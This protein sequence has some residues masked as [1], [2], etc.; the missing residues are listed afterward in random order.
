VFYTRILS[1]LKARGKTIVVITHDDRYFH[2]ADQI[3]KLD[4]GQREDVEAATREPLAHR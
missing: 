3:V 4:F 1:D 2:C